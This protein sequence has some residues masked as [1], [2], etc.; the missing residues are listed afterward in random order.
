MFTGLVEEV[1]TV[2]SVTPVADGA[3]VVIDAAVVLEDAVIGA[4]IAV[5]GCCLTVVEIDGSGWTADAVPETLDRTTIGGLEAGDRVNLERPLA[6]NGRYGGHVVQG[7][8]DATTAVRSIEELAD[9]SFRYTFEL[10][11]TMADYVVE[12]GSIA[13]DGISLTVAAVAAASFS[14]AVIPH[15]HEVTTL[16]SRTVGDRVNLEADVLAKYV[17][18]LVR[19]SL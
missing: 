1:G 15:T 3:K 16:G 7:H 18:R 13:V 5:N 14:I 10:P 6:A 11:A 4:S 17:E 12:K 8:V 19:P 9:G 2:R